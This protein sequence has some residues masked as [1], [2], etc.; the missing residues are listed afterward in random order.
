M[1]SD[2]FEP[3]R[4]G[5]SGTVVDETE[6]FRVECE[7]VRLGEVLADVFAEGLVDV[8]FGVP[9]E[10]GKAADIANGM[11]SCIGV[12]I[13]KGVATSSGGERSLSRSVAYCVR[14]S[15]S[16]GVGVPLRKQLAHI[17]GA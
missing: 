2:A 4:D 10:E 9:V 16:H 3:L 6:D 15:P 11:S 8:A 14:T 17:T 7:F 13:S 1:S 12:P 5:G